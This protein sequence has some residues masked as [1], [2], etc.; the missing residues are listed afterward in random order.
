MNALRGCGIGWRGLW[1][2][3]LFL[4]PGLHSAPRAAPAICETE[5]AARGPLCCVN[6]LAAL[7]GPIAGQWAVGRGRETAG[8]AGE[9]RSRGP[10][11]AGVWAAFA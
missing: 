9:G 7:S 10:A 11:A 5:G 3:P 4:P 2:S 8:E 6:D 1:V